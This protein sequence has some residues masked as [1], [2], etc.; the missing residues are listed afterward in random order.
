MYFYMNSPF[1]CYMV[2]KNNVIMI[3]HAE[4]LFMI[5]HVIKL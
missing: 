4:F 1:Q 3:F 2:T 5:N